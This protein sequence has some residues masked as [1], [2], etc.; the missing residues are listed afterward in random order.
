M[1]SEFIKFTFLICILSSV[2]S[3]SVAV[4]QHDIEV[5]SVLAPGSGSNYVEPGKRPAG[6]DSQVDMYDSLPKNLSVL[7]ESM[8]LD[9]FKP[10]MFEVSSDDIA[11]ESSPRP[12]LRIVRDKTHNVPHISGDTRAA[13]MFGVGYVRAA[14]RLWQMDSFRAQWR[15]E[16]TV[17]LGRGENDAN[18]EFDANTFRLIDYSED[19]YQKMFDRLRVAYGSWG[20]Q[21]ANDIEE[22]VAGFNAYLDRIDN[23]NSLL[24]VE[25]ANRGLKPKRW[26]V[27]DVMAMAAYSHVSWGSAGPGEEANAQLLRQLQKKFGDDA[28]NVFHDLRSAPSANYKF[29][30]PPVTVDTY[31]TNP[32]SIALLDI[33]SFEERE[34]LVIGANAAVRGSMSPRSHNVRSNALLVAAV[35]STTGRPIAVQGPQD[36]YGT[37]HLFDSEI[38]IVAPDFKARGILELSGPYP[39]VAARGENYAWSITILPPDQADTFVEVLCEPAAAA[40]TLESMHYVYKSECIPFARREDTKKIRDGNDTYTLISLRSVH[41]PVIGRATVDAKPVAVAQARSMYMHEEMD[42]PAHAQLFSP[43]VVRSAAD[44]IEILAGTAYN[45]GWWYID[46]KD[47]AGVDAGLVPIR[48]KGASTD[49]P[50]WGSGEWDWRGFD[51]ETYTFRSPLKSQYPQAINGPDGV[52]AGWNNPSALGWSLKDEAW[53]VSSHDRVQL[54]KEPT[55]AAVN[56]RQISIVDLLK[57]H[58]EAAVTDY[59]AQRLYP[60][61][62]EFIGSV[63]NRELEELLEATD[64]WSQEGGLLLDLDG[65]GFLEHSKS[66]AFL[67]AFWINLVRDIFQPVLGTEILAEAGRTNN[68]PPLTTTPA[69]SGGWISKIVSELRLYMGQAGE[70]LSRNYCGKTKAHCRSLIVTALSRAVDA[71]KTQYGTDIEKWKVAATCDAGCRQIEFAPT[72]DM[73]PVSPIAW[74]NRGTYIQ[75][76]TGN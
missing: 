74:Q 45:I 14:D 54:L 56:E 8:L 6:I 19:E 41:G 63:R 22:Y 15:A 37:P 17:L 33:D 66:I 69:S 13:A 26:S 58:T 25:Y 36:G 10:A 75:V 7:D 59:R 49:L 23:D 1:R 39:Y 12:G 27:T 24:P 64:V 31:A 16:S 28:Q 21:A 44:F 51:A 11:S 76:T 30:L 4:A 32:D 70:Q 73:T 46:Q 47:I 5:L 61:I 67:E 50:I 65:D 2:L 62:R 53:N 43:S 20:I 60:S 52:I 29:S 55:V 72:G 35:H 9:F 48:A 40:P 42:F 18:V 71:A 3:L 68:L 38:S 57:I 34:I